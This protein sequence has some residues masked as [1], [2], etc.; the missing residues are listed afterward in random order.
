MPQGTEEV[1]R[2]TSVTERT[3]WR[4]TIRNMMLAAIIGNLFV[5]AASVGE[6][7]RELRG[8]REE[9]HSSRVAP[10]EAVNQEQTCEVK[11]D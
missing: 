5:M 3:A 8:I 11:G 9:L 1:G 10:P 4:D 7:K 6:I 2:A